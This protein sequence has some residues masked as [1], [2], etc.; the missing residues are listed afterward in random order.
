MTTKIFTAIVLSIA[1]VTSSFAAKP[2][3]PMATREIA[4][5]A[6]FE[7]IAVDEYI[8]VVIVQDPYRLTITVS[9]DEKSIASV[10][11]SIEN[12][13]LRIF[14][15]RRLEGKK[16]TVYIP[17]GNISHIDLSAG[18]SVSG[19]GTLKFPELSV[20]VSPDSRVELSILG[21]ISINSKADCNL[22]YEKHE[23]YKM[24]PPEL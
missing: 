16:I 3:T 21:D 18:S 13:K 12:N 17:V 11:T 8:S 9:G 19:E 10:Q 22:V 15:K 1:F 23:T 24:V 6:Q 7:E 5:L 14:S 2:R 20:L 4:I